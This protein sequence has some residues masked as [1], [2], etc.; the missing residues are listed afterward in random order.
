MLNIQTSKEINE[1]NQ[2]YTKEAVTVMDE[3]LYG[4]ILDLHAQRPTRPFEI[5]HQGEVLY[6]SVGWWY[7]KE[8]LKYHGF[9]GK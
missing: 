4:M 7:A 3:N 2:E 5:V 9:K 6:S 1:L 8:N